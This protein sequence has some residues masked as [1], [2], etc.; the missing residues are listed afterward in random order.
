MISLLNNS[1][2]QHLD[3]GWKKKLHFIKKK[4]NHCRDEDEVEI[5]VSV[6]DEDGI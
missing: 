6:K 2:L 3:H 1:T 5:P 4:I